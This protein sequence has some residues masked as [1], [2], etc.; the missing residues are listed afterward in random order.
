MTADGTKLHYVVEGSG[1]PC[2]VVNGD[3]YRRVFSKDLRRHLKLVFVDFRHSTEAEAAAKIDDITLDTLLDDIDQV[4]KA[5]GFDRVA[6]MGH[7][8]PSAIAFEYARKYPEHT[9][10]L[11]LIGS[12]PFMITP[13]ESEAFWQSD[14]SEARKLADKRNLE[15]ITD[16]DLKKAPPGQ[17]WKLLFVRNG[18][19]YW[20]DPSYDSSW[21]LEGVAPNMNFMPHVFGLFR[22]YDV[23]KRRPRA[24]MPIFLALG[25]YDYLVPYNTW[26]GRKDSFPN[27]SYNLFEKSGHCPMF[28]EPALFDKQLIEWMKRNK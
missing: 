21:M 12:P 22:D 28:E 17:A 27:L 25:R 19:H 18:A 24:T 16:E 26:D 4:R 1:I 10:H 11:I 9:S 6:V 20:Y 7:S 13:K 5:L 2:I 23:S 8:L 3:Y 14:A 15:K